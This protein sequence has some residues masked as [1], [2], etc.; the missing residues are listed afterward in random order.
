MGNW[1]A[2]ILR[3]WSIPVGRIGNAHVRVHLSFL[4]LLAYVWMTDSKPLGNAV[5]GRG[6]ALVGLMLASVIL[7]EL[8]HGLVTIHRKLPVRVLVLMPIGG[9]VLVDESA[10]PD[11]DTG[12]EWAVALSGPFANLFVAFITGSIVLGLI[13]KAALWSSPLISSENLLRSFVWINFALFAMNLVP[14]Y[15]LD[16]GRIL[17]STLARRTDFV[18]ATR[19]AV[20]L[21][22]MFAIALVL[23][24]IIV[25]DVWNRWLMLV[26]LVLFLAAQLEHRAVLF[27]SVLESLRL[28]DV[29]LTDFAVLSPADTLEDALN[30]AVH[31]LQD[32]FPVIR[33]GDMVGVVS[34]QRIVEEL[35]GEGNGY[36]QSAMNRAFQIA[37]KGESLASALR[38]LTAQRLTLIPVVDEG[39]LVGI[40]TFQ[41]LMHS[42]RLLAE[43]RRLKNGK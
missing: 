24:G 16:A 10:E 1:A 3:S 22:Q 20:S 38:K 25:P 6:L 39:R 31:T 7:H 32:D 11:H 37:Q 9:I 36:V 26:G 35:R 17:R 28:E 34:R 15:P 43:S 18:R 41:N 19:Q 5:Y 27:Q 30:K 2:S 33:G 12:G 13:P 4:F 42:M 14:A 40:I 29:M 21:G 23:P 8:A